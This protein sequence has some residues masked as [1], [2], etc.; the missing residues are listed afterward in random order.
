MMMM[1]MKISMTIETI[2]IISTNSWVISRYQHVMYIILF[3]FHPNHIKEALF[4]KW[5]N[6]SLPRFNAW[7]VSHHLS[8]AK[9]GFELSSAPS[10]VS[11]NHSTFMFHGI[12]PKTLRSEGTCSLG[13]CISPSF[14]NSCVSWNW[15]LL[16]CYSRDLQRSQM[17]DS[18]LSFK[19]CFLKIIG[20]V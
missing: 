2:T 17:K 6:G 16:S 11:A 5:G 3:N 10:R 15:F 8:V 7:P 19:K 12:G 9:L 1:M 20:K 13:S 18:S 4:Y 14:Q